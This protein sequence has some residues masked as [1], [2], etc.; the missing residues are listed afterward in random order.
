MTK[1]R[2]LKLAASKPRPKLPPASALAVAPGS[3]F[4]A[5]LIF[6]RQHK[7]GYVDVIE[8]LCQDAVR[9]ERKKQHNDKRQIAEA[10][11]VARTAPP[12]Q[13][14]MLADFAE[15]IARHPRGADV[16]H[17]S[18]THLLSDLDASEDDED[19]GTL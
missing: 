15:L 14:P 11:R 9:D 7:P 17:G 10:R 6:L 8:K 18:I 4:E 12:S 5:D 19:E 13:S 16:I 1:A 2:V 3:A